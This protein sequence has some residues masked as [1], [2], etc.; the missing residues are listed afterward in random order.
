MEISKKEFLKEEELCYVEDLKNYN[1]SNDIVIIA[2]P[3]VESK[4]EAGVIKSE[5]VVKAEEEDIYKRPFM[6][7]KINED[8][9]IK[10]GNEYI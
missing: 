10:V 3:S 4:T 2:I 9:N 5:E 7:I 6:V 8:N 1:L